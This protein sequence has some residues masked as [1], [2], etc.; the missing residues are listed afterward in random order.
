MSEY[1]AYDAA[2]ATVNDEEQWLRDRYWLVGSGDVVLDLGAYH[3]SYT[4]P[5]LAVGARVYAVDGRSDVLVDL[6][7][8]AAVEGLA[9][10]LLTIHLALSNGKPYPPALVEAIRTG[11]TPSRDMVPNAKWGTVD[12]LV[13]DYGVGHVDWIKVDVEGGELAVLQGARKTLALDHPKLIV[14]DHTNVYPYVARQ[15]NTN[16]LT[17]LLYEYGYDVELVE[18]E[19]SHYPNYVLA[20]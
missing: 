17:T 11:P 13:R 14:E 15:D 1:G 20:R 5:A 8:R 9:D 7:R 16:Q 4:L 6:H 12:L 19:P 10:R 2:T 3:G 18:S